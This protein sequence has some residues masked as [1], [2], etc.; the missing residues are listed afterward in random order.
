M[1]ICIFI[2]DLPGGGVDIKSI[3]SDLTPGD[4]KRNANKIATILENHLN[5][6]QSKMHVYG[7]AEA[8]LA[9]EKGRIEKQVNEAEKGKKSC[10][11]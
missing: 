1:K 3:R 10:L 4:E 11:H 2:E 9:K 5:E 8:L 6:L 7:K